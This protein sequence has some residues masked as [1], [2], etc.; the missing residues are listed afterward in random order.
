MPL[1]D[2]RFIQKNIAA[3][4]N[5][6]TITQVAVTIATDEYR[7]VSEVDTDN[8]NIPCFVHVLS[9]EDEIVKQGQAR[10][11]DLIIWFDYSYNSILTRSGNDKIRITWNSDTYEI[12]NIK[13]FYAEGDT[14]L[15]LECHVKQI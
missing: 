13:P 14:I 10:S 6:C 8:T 15:L 4:G 7:T 11:G 5:T 9:Y 12:V 3:V 2:Q 1:L